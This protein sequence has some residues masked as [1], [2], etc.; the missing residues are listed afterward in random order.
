[1]VDISVPEKVTDRCYAGLNCKG[2]DP[3]PDLGM[4]DLGLGLEVRSAMLCYAQ[5]RKSVKYDVTRVQRK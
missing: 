5:E 2:G 4:V 3:A 1:M